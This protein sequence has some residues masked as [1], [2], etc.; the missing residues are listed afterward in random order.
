VNE[1]LPT[2]DESRTVV[3]RRGFAAGDPNVLCWGSVARLGRRDAADSV[4]DPLRSSEGPPV[5]VRASASWKAPGSWSRQ[6]P[7]SS[8][9]EW[10]S[11]VSCV[12]AVDLD[13]VATDHEVRVDVG[14]VDAHVS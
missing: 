4:V 9:E 13:L 10:H 8:S 3:A 1:A 12:E 7:I 11:V 2:T 6:L 5:R 14:A